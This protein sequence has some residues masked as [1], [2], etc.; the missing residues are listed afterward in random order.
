MLAHAGGEDEYPHSTPYA[1]AESV[2]AGV[3]VLDFDVQL[4]ADGVLV[5]QHDDN[6]DRTTNGTGNVAEMTYAQLA[7]LDNAYWFTAA[8]TCRDQPPRRLHLPR[9]SA[10]VRHHRPPATHPTT[11]SSLASATSP[12]GSPISPSTSRS[13]PQARPAIA[14]AKQ[15]AAELTEL[16]L[17]DNAVVAS[18]D[19]TIVDTFH[20]FAPTVEVTPGLN[21]V[22]G[23]HP[24]RH[25]TAGRHAHPAGARRLR[26]HQGAHAGVDRRITRGRLRDL[27][28]AQRPRLGERRGLRELLGM[29][30]DGLNINY[31]APSVSTP[32]RR[33][34]PA[35]TGR[36]STAGRFLR[37]RHR[38]AHCPRAVDGHRARAG[39]APSLLRR[40]LATCALTRTSSTSSRT[41]TTEDAPSKVFAVD[42]PGKPASVSGSTRTSSGR[43]SSSTS[44]LARVQ[45]GAGNCDRGAGDH[46]RVRGRAPSPAARSSNRRS[47]PRTRS[48]ACCTPRSAWPAARAGRSTSRRRGRR[49]RAPPPGRG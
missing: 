14:T 48:T 32:S 43:T 46:H 19:D 25:A 16:D 9:A 26:R 29:G 13:S 12:S 33:S 41:P 31:P 44:P 35:E 17:L 18:F 4:T 36:L 3:D 45:P 7:E 5:V 1:Y 23:V 39:R 40:L 15:L 37:R 30:L 24:Q 47:G 2:A 8:C 21:A 6:V 20:E 42:G 34:T 49:C 28:V 10:P 11:S 38:F 22:L 27:G